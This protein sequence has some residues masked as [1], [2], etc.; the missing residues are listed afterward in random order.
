[1]VAVPIENRSAVHVE[2]TGRFILPTPPE[3]ALSFLTPEGERLWV[4]GWDP[5]AHHAP[6]GTLS[7]AGAVFTTAHGGEE[8]LWMVLAFDRAQ[9]HARYARI[10]PGSRL[11]TVDVRCRARDRGTEVEVTYSLT[12]LSSGGAEKLA[13]LTA[14]AYREMLDD[15]RGK[16]EAIL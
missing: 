16:I 15:W 10:T 7:A 5:V 8:T 12:S 4:D 9:G 3:R 14:D 1:L 13:A 6:D 2:R 11:G